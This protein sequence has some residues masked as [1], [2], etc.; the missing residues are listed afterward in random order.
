[1]FYNARKLEEDTA[2]SSQPSHLPLSS[3]SEEAPI[4]T[5]YQELL[6]SWNM[7]NATAFAALFDNE[8][9]VIGFD[10][11][12]MNGRVEIE[13]TIR[14]IFMDHVTAPYVGKVRGIR[15]L[16]PEVAILHAVVGMISPVTSDINPAVNAMQTLVAMKQDGQW[17][18]ALFQNTPA[19]F[20]GRPEVAEALTEELRELLSPPQ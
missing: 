1:M 11:S 14:Q 4:I 5:L 10:G 6:N 3:T 15:F 9:I 20:H 19:Q 16:T 18:I 8:A 13:A 12:S 7:H 2:M 17:R